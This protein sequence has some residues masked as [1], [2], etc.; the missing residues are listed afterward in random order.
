MRDSLFLDRD[1]WVHI[2]ENLIAKEKANR[3]ILALIIFQKLLQVLSKL[4]LIWIN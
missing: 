1:S 2:L 4:L 3:N